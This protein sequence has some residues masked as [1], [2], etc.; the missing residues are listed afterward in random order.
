MKSWK[1]KIVPILFVIGGIGWL[2]G[3]LKQFIK[4]EPIR[5]ANIVFACVSFM[6]AVVLARKARGNASTPSA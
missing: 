4:D 3:P 5:G 1:Y 2:I 6:F